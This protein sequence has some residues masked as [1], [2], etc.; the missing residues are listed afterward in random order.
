MGS[1]KRVLTCI[2]LAASLEAVLYGLSFPFFSI[3]LMD[4]GVSLSLVGLNASCG[5]VGILLCGRMFP[6]LLLRMGYRNFSV[7]CFMLALCSVCVL[8]MPGPL[9]TWYVARLVLGV[10]QAGL[11]IATDAWF[12]HEVSNDTR[13]RA[14]GIFQAMYSCGLLVGLGATYLTGFAGQ[15]P[16]L[17][18]MT[19]CL[20]ALLALAMAGSAGQVDDDM[21]DPLRWRDL[22]RLMGARDILLLSLLAGLAETSLYALLPVY[23]MRLGLS[24]GTAVG[25]LLAFTLGGILVVIP[26]GWLADRFSKDA[27]QAI[28]A[29]VGAGAVLVLIPV[30]S[31]PFLARAGAFVAGGLIVSL[32]NIASVQA[33]ARFSQARLPLL[34][35]ALT[36]CYA[37][38]SSSGAAVGGAAIQ[39]LGPTGLPAV[40]GAVLA[41][42]ATAMAVVAVRGWSLRATLAATSVAADT[43]AAESDQPTLPGRPQPV[44]R[45]IGWA[46][47]TDGA[48]DRS[49]TIPGWRIGWA[50]QT[51]L[52]GAAAVPALASTGGER[53]SRPTVP[54]WQ[55]DWARQTVGPRAD[56]SPVAPAK[57]ARGRNR[58]G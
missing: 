6:R 44:T 38:G 2:V 47:A 54:G 32:S 51:V 10:G 21:A 15:L 43:P 25:L 30:A 40:I 45:P 17:L 33:G 8:L 37:I 9:I 39:L 11:W 36:I 23:G 20:A 24:P 13:G 12:N 55:I 3:R 46:V 5:A 22:L 57:P 34:T 53:D 29:A 50:A 26:V 19:V 48:R 31:A 58:D 14:N 56:A 1:S 52:P 35:T 16:V 28:C 7:I 4:A 49:M 41:I 27:V 42:S 18:M